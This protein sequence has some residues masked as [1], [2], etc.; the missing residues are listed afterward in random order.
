MQL[1]LSSFTSV[2]LV[3]VLWLLAGNMVGTE[4]KRIRGRNQ[5]DSTN[6]S[7]T[8]Y[9]WWD[10]NMLANFNAAN[11]ARIEED[12]ARQEAAIELARQEAAIPA[13]VPAPVPVPAPAPAPSVGP[14]AC[15][16][17]LGLHLH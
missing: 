1:S 6:E 8:L 2:T 17:C 16:A 9:D 4:G 7:R 3:L 10:N 5:D 15:L 11:R 12:R 14:V 13:P